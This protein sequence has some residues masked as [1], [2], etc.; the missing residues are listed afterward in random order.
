MSLD[1]LLRIV[2]MKGRLY[3]KHSAFLMPSEIK[4]LFE[5]YELLS[6]V[7]GAYC[8]YYDFRFPLI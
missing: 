7:A 6:L 4:N 5:V 2:V 8:N 1:V 3:N